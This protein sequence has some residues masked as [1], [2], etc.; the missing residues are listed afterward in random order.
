MQGARGAEGGAA[1]GGSAL[2][3]REPRLGTG[4]GGVRDDRDTVRRPVDRRLWRGREAGDQTGEGSDE[5]LVIRM[6]VLRMTRWF[7]RV[8]STIV[9]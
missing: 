9:V 1:L 4:A 6:K 3:G 2:G 5:N 7:K 8:G